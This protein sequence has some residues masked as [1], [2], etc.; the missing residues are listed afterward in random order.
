VNMML[1]FFIPYDMFWQKGFKQ[2]CLSA[3]LYFLVIAE[4]L[5]L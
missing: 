5:F 3:C 1:N 2:A 4:R